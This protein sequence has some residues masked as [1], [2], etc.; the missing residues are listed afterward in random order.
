MRRAWAVALLGVLALASAGCGDRGDKAMAD[1]QSGLAGI[2]RGVLDLRFT[3]GKGEQAGGHDVGFALNG[4]FDMSGKPGTLPVAR[5]RFTRLLGAKERS[6]EFVSTGDRAWA[7]SSGGSKA[8]ELKAAD[9]QPLRLS[10]AS[11][12]TSGVAGLDF[13]SWARGTPTTTKDGDVE[14]IVSDVD[15]VQVINDVMGMAGQFGAGVGPVEGKAAERLRQAV[16]RARMTV[17][18]GAKDRLVRQVTVDMAVVAAQAVE[19]LGDMAAAHLHLE[20]KV[21]RPNQAI[22]PVSPPR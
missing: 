16:Q 13:D 17:V 12:K 15:A 19:A 21:D 3:A 9:L 8:V 10:S 18:V 22:G 5:L 4:P 11:G 2:K 1:A 14:R 20:L 7:V 6:A